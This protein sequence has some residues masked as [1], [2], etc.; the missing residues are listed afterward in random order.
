MLL[1]L[2][3]LLEMFQDHYTYPVQDGPGTY[4]DDVHAA[5]LAMSDGVHAAGPSMIVVVPDA[6]PSVT[7]VVDSSSPVVYIAEQHT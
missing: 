5:G 2:L 1:P 3:I 6:L 7:V 4:I